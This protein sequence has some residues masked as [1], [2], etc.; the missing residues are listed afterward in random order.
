M[1]VI[2]EVDTPAVDSPRLSPRRGSGSGSSPIAS[3]ARRGSSPS[4]FPFGATLVGGCL[5]DGPAEVLADTFSNSGHDQLG[6]FGELELRRADSNEEHAHERGHGGTWPNTP[7]LRVGSRRLN[8]KLPP[9]LTESLE[10][11]VIAEKEQSQSQ[12]QGQGHHE[13]LGAVPEESPAAR[14]PLSPFKS[15]ARPPLQPIKSGTMQKI[16][17]LHHSQGQDKEK[18]HRR[19]NSVS[20]N[21]SSRPSALPRSPSMPSVPTKGGLSLSPKRPVF[22]RLGTPIT[23]PSFSSSPRRDESQ[24]P[25]WSSSPYDSPPLPA[26]P[27]PSAPMPTPAFERGAIEFPATPHSRSRSR[28][29]SGE[30][31]G[32]DASVAV[33]DASKR[34]D[35]SQL[36]Y[37]SELE[38]SDEEGN[39]T[40]FGDLVGGPRRTVV[41]FVRH[42]LSSFCAQYLKALMAELPPPL[43]AGARARMIIIGHGSQEMIANFRAH[44]HCPFPV[45]TDP[46]RKLHDTLGL[47]PHPL[48]PHSPKG[49]YVVQNAVVRACET[50]QLATKLHGFR[51]GDRDQ[52]G[53][54]FVFD[55]SLRVVYSHRMSG[56]A[57]HAPVHELLAAAAETTT[58]QLLH[59]QTCSR[60]R[61]NSASAPSSRPR[62]HSRATKNAIPE[63]ERKLHIEPALP[64]QQTEPVSPISPTSDAEVVTPR[65]T[66]PSL[67]GTNSSPS[68]MHTLT[69]YESTATPDSPSATDF[70][71]PPLPLSVT[72]EEC[73]QWDKQRENLLARRSRARTAFSDELAI[74]I[75]QPEDVDSIT[76]E[77]IRSSAYST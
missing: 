60:S 70:P 36:L 14:S 75:V 52:L 47:L 4:A 54:E 13:P 61:S 67:P 30:Q 18:D 72:L 51:A 49:G 1:D 8:R 57:D 56:V 43:L 17:Q 50:L 71:L 26:R 69:S 23:L 55:G 65:T 73:E 19:S 25:G 27:V 41:V 62:A 32:R 39:R 53:G 37:A 6:E 42:W 24:S 5:P 22:K 21:S 58:S 7:P 10:A 45:Y 35:V 68:S 2:A 74:S 34:P 40:R 63:V 46:T 44:F 9:S 33:F 3:P 12:G 16:M 48:V 66:R 59:R 29:R 31:D 28:S 64:P 20:V 38:V 76:G 15:F 77:V 11:L